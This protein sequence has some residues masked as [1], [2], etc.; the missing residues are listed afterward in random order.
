[1]IHLD[2]IKLRNWRS[3]KYAKFEF[4]PAD[5]QRNVI[6]IT[7][8][9]ECGKT[10]FFEALVLGLYGQ[11]GLRLAPRARKSKGDDEAR[12]MNYSRFMESVLH[13]DFLNA[14]QRLNAEQ[15]Q[16]LTCE[17]EIAFKLNSEPVVIHRIWHFDKERN[18][19]PEDDDLRILRSQGPVAP[20]AIDVEDRDKWYS[21]YIARSFLPV[22]LANFFLFDGEQAQHYASLDMADQVKK[23]IKGL[24]GLTLLESLA[25]DLQTYARRE[26]SHVSHPDEEALSNLANEIEELQGRIRTNEE[27]INTLD[28]EITDLNRDSDNLVRKMEEDDQ[29][30]MTDIVDLTKEEEDYRANAREAAQGVSDLLAGE[31][32]LMLVGEELLNK[33]VSQLHA[34]RKREEW[35]QGRAQGDEKFNEYHADLSSRLLALEPPVGKALQKKILQAVKAAWQEIW[36]PLPEGAA[37]SYLHKSLAGRVRNQA[38]EK[39]QEIDQEINQKLK[40]LAQKREMA[41]KAA[42]EKKLQRMAAQRRK[43]EVAKN[44][45][46]TYNAIRDRIRSLQSKKQETGRL[47][48]KL[49]S[50]AGSKNSELQRLTS[51]ITSDSIQRAK[52]AERVSALIQRV[53]QETIPHQTKNIGDAMTAAWKKMS[54]MPDRVAEINVTD[55]CEVEMLNT[56]G[57]DIRKVDRSAGGE[58]IFTQALFWS[59][60]HVSQHEFPFVVDTPLARLSHENRLGVIRQFTDHSGQVILL[61]TDTEVVGE[62]LDAIRDKIAISWRLDLHEYENGIGHTTVTRL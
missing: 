37:D 46:E 55:A 57:E 10:S 32:A 7:G 25:E 9:S 27:L 59:V 28:N 50:E 6:L 30:S 52:Y 62:V 17:V 16:S 36:R 39:L 13:E 12:T 45:R 15:Q 29:D 21:D 43:P 3:Y 56:N 34:E 38:A 14:E 44:E 8:V 1:M 24:L 51:Y 4:P 33:T 53:V 31:M 11:R 2:Y 47:Q 58:Q 48:E 20:P 54:H 41:L 22:D 49:R 60:T 5:E 23:G 18:H 35:E 61:S 19:L 40:D 42:E 26:R